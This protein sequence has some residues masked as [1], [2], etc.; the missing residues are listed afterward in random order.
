M[1]DMNEIIKESL[2]GIKNFADVEKVIGKVINT[3]SGVT[4]IPI[5]KLTVGFIG[6]GA[7][8]GQKRHSQ[9]QNFGCGSGTGVSI[10]PIA[11]LTVTPDSEVNIIPVNDE[12]ASTDRLLTLIERSPEIIE[13]IKS[14]MS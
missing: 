4:I 8:Y 13:R 5:S 2:E 11:F 6:G 3:P 10:S 7:D 1:S 9:M 14:I 12:K